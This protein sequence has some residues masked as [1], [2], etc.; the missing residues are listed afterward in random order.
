MKSNAGLHPLL[1]VWQVVT[2][3]MRGT[4]AKIVRSDKSECFEISASFSKG[5]KGTVQPHALSFRFTFT[6][7]ARVPATDLTVQDHHEH[8]QRRRT[9]ACGFTTCRPL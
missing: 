9:G 2:T 6:G 1:A 7:L 3:K 4:L 5:E 8:E